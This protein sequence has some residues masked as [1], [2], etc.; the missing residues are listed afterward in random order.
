MFLPASQGSAAVAR[1][2]TDAPAGFD[3][4]GSEH[5]VAVDVYFGGRKIGEALAISRPGVLKFRSPDGLLEAIPN[6]IVTPDLEAAIGGELPTNSDRACAA[7]NAKDC[8]LLNPELLGIIYNEDRFRVDLFVNRK[9]L[10]TVPAGDQ[11]YLPSPDSGFSAT[12]TFGVDASGTIGGHSNYNLQNRTIFAIRDARIRADTAV[13][14]GLG[15]LV[16]DL[17]AEVDRRDLRYSGGLFWAPANEFVGQRRILGAGIGTQFD[18]WA[19][20]ESLRSTPLVVFLPDPARIDVVVDARLVS[21]RSYPAGNVEVDTSGLAEGSYPVLLRIEHA[22][23]SVEEQRRFFVKN[24]QVPATGH[25]IFYAYAGVLANTRKDEPISPSNTIF[26][27]AGA[28]RRLTNNIA[29]D[30]EALG[31]QHKAMVE[32]GGWLLHSGAR[33]RAAGLVSSAGDWGALVQL[34]TAASGPFSMSLDVRRIWSRDGGPLIPLPSSI[35]SFD[36]APNVGVQLANGSYTQ[37]TASLG[38]RLANG[39][40][41][42]VGSYRK[43]RHFPA[44]Y[45]IGPNLSMPL[46]TRNDVQLVFEASAERTRTTTAAFA[47]L[48]LLLSSGHSAI[49]ARIGYAS[50]QDKSG[51]EPSN[52][53]LVGNV[54]EQLS[55]QTAGGTLMNI[56]A[57]ADRNITSS[58]VHAEGLISSRLGELRADLLQSLE[59]DRER[60]QYNLAFQSGLAIGASASIWG[61]RELEQSAIIVSVRGDAKDAA[62]T[63]LV[64]DTPR[65][66]VVVGHHL[67]LFVPA[68]RSYRVRLVPTASE[69]ISFDTAEH[70]VTLYPGNVRTLSWSADSYFTIFGQA[71]SPNGSP[72]GNALVESP[73]GIAETDPNG[74]FQIDLRNGDPVK[75]KDDGNRSCQLSLGK[76]TPKDDFASVGKVICE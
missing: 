27:E 9:F 44:D 23:G 13:A 73:K 29:L 41:S 63:V 5:V 57:D 38:L 16:D 43:D 19:D 7:S 49:G 47:G 24:S 25:P 11:G 48:R 42:V 65:G 32:A 1:L 22:N 33:L 6:L 50:Q 64:D 71:L 45:T 30:V 70:D 12:D 51:S 68:Y 58:T 34:A 54:S 55:E 28:A 10:R 26:Y 53:R 37:A 75:I 21:S 8:G 60:P 46:I 39:F 40:L 56:E 36:V 3:E 69:S 18:T 76:V 62:F 74:Y 14:S 72:L 15:V 67:A 4:L 61:S 52:S 2:S 31:T 59:G 35:T 17:V 66:K 20:H